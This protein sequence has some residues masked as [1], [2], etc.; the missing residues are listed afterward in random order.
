MKFISSTLLSFFLLGTICTTLQASF[1]VVTN[2]FWSGG[3]CISNLQ[4]V[5]TGKAAPFSFV[6]DNGQQTIL[7]ESNLEGGLYTFELPMNGDFNIVVTDALGCEYEKSINS[8]CDCEDPEVNITQ[9]SCHQSD[10]VIEIIP[11]YLG[12]VQIDWTDWPSESEQPSNEGTVFSNLAA[13]IYSANLIVTYTQGS[14]DFPQIVE[15]QIEQYNFDLDDCECRIEI[16]TDLLVIEDPESCYTPDGSISVESWNLGNIV[17]NYSG[18]TISDLDIEW[19]HLGQI[20]S[21]D[22]PFTLD[23]L[24]EG[25]YI[26]KVSDGDC[27]AQTVVNLSNPDITI[28]ENIENACPGSSDGSIFISAIDE[29]FIEIE[30]F[31]WNTGEISNEI[32]NLAV[33]TYSVIATSNNSGC[34][35]TAV[36][37]VEE[38][39]NDE[40]S[41]ITIEQIPGRCIGDE[42][43]ILFDVIGGSPP[44][45]ISVSPNATSMGSVNTVSVIDDCGE[46]YSEEFTI[47]VDNDYEQMSMSYDTHVDC[48]EGIQVNNTTVTITGGSYSF[49]VYSNGVELSTSHLNPYKKYSIDENGDNTIITLTLDEGDNIVEVIDACG[50]SISQYIKIGLCDISFTVV[51]SSSCQVYLE[52]APNDQNCFDNE[53]EFVSGVSCPSCDESLVGLSVHQ[54]VIEPFI[55]WTPEY[56][57]YLWALTSESAGTY[58]IIVETPSGCT[59]EYDIIIGDCENPTV[60]GGGG[61]TTYPDGGP[62]GYGPVSSSGSDQGFEVTATGVTCQSE[63]NFE[64]TYPVPSP[65]SKVTIEYYLCNDPSYSGSVEISPNESYTLSVPSDTW[66]GDTFE[67]CASVQ[68]LASTVVVKTTTST[69]AFAPDDDCI[70]YLIE[71]DENGLTGQYT[72][73]SS[74]SNTN[75]IIGPT[76]SNFDNIYWINPNWVGDG[77]FTY[78]VGSCPTINPP[79]EISAFVGDIDPSEVQGVSGCG[80]YVPLDD[81]PEW[82]SFPFPIN[83]PVVFPTVMTANN[84]DN[85]V[86]PIV[87]GVTKYGCYIY[88]QPGVKGGRTFKSEYISIKV[89]ESGI[90]YIRNQKIKVGLLANVVADESS[91]VSFDGFSTSPYLPSVF[92]AVQSNGLNSAAYATQYDLY[93]SNG[94]ALIIGAKNCIQTNSS[95]LVGYIVAE[96]ECNDPQNLDTGNKVLSRESTKQDNVSVYPNPTTSGFTI[97]LSSKIEVSKI[98]VYSLNGS[99]VDTLDKNASGIYE[100]DLRFVNSGIYIIEV[101]DTEGKTYKKRISKL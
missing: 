49:S 100:V 40:I 42:P 56:K 62:S 93:S 16:N 57:V 12:M 80:F 19:S 30:N 3:E 74:P 61:T 20:V 29:N 81:S 52:V 68:Y 4:I 36:Y 24:E 15:C 91:Y 33:G 7:Q 96:N 44:Y 86:T 95:E 85:S 99:V 8:N 31:Q 64:F 10:G 60:P 89:F 53:D 67:V 6:V 66:P 73:S 32:S 55:D 72:Y 87:Y 69:C 58:P 65:I 48:S 25:P 38:K 26:L 83:D 18:S 5:I 88:L 70:E 82:I 76:K 90:G 27:S 28:F 1:E 37:T 2:S 22:S 46:I 34:T 54:P 94:I 35:A 45:D 11:P 9:S 13:G 77:S 97:V 71:N 21:G 63:I 50:N 17:S 101:V 78:S 75:L 59:Y 47:D 51:S 98:V 79:T 92:A 39:D 14:Q 41:D 84:D 23:D 43:R